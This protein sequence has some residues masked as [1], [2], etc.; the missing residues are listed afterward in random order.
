MKE[1]FIK[2]WASIKNSKRL[3][4]FLINILALIIIIFVTII[5]TIVCINKS[6]KDDPEA[7]QSAT[8]VDDESPVKDSRPTVTLDYISAFLAKDSELTTG[9]LKTNGFMNYKS[10][11]G[12]PGITK[13]AFGML[14]EAEIRAG[15]LLEQAKIIGIDD[16]KRLIYISLPDAQILDT[17]VNPKEIKYIDE[18]FALIP[19][20][21]KEHANKAQSVAEEHAFEYAKTTGILEFADDHAKTLVRNLF[22]GA[23]YDYTVEF[24]DK[25]FDISSISI[26]ETENTETAETPETY[27]D[28]KAE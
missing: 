25:N 6:N 9:R 20:D 14:Y 5:A 10:E 22:E 18:K 23:I 24:V 21:E 4:K 15:I 7:Q 12:V 17:K 11:K 2:K 8:Y 28:P 27:N 1:K 26:E 3:K 16:E 19:I 13:I